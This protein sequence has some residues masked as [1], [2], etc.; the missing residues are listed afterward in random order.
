MEKDV[1]INP[2]VFQVLMG[3]FN[4]S[5]ITAWGEDNLNPTGQA[6]E[7]VLLRFDCCFKDFY[8]RDHCPETGI[9]TSKKKALFLESDN[10]RL[11]ENL[12][13]PS[14]SWYHGPFADKGLFLSL[15]IKYDRY[16]HGRPAPEKSIQIKKST[17]GTRNW[18]SEQTANTARFDL[19][20]V[21]IKPPKAFKLKGRSVI[22]RVF[23][24]KGTQSAP[25][26]H[27][28]IDCL[29]RA[30]PLNERTLE[31]DSLKE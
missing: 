1:Q 21:P 22:R 7:K 5:R 31:E 26:D 20:C 12:V 19:I 4:T 29:L 9:R 28:P 10:E 17:W 27:L 13:E 3:D 24:P 18:Y 6:E 8:L 25:S 15:K 23:V 14:G 30:I 2:N 11:D 16:R